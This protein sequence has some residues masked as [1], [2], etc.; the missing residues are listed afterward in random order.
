VPNGWDC[1]NASHYF[2]SEGI[3]FFYECDV[4]SGK[5]YKFAA[6]MEKIE[7]IKLFVT[8]CANICEMV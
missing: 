4:I 7:I 3:S 8:A 1:V 5:F 2:L 6:K